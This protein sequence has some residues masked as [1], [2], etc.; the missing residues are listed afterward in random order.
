[1]LVIVGFIVV[2]VSIL[3][4][5]M[6]AGGNPILLLQFAEFIV[7]GGSAIG[8]VLIAAPMK[9]IKKIMSEL[10]KTI[11]QEHYSKE[12]FLVLLKS[13]N[14]LFLVAQRDGLL[15]IERH[16]EKPEESEILSRSKKFIT[17]ETTRSFFCDSMK[18][19]LSGGIPPHELES[20][21]EAEIETFDMESKPV[22]GQISK[23][24]D[25]LPGLGIVAA[26]LGIIVTMSSIDDG[27][28]AVG[29]HV[30]A[31]LVGTFLGV[32]MA[33]GFVNPLA[34]NI[35]HNV[36]ARVRLLETIK[37][38]ITAYAKGNP[39]IVA[40]EIARRTIFSDERPTFAELEGF[41]R[42]KS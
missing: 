4:G 20:L 26:V 37:T 31:A 32:L 42:A 39:P 8:S 5:F 23:M 24:G 12:D 27:A 2:I 17:N 35:E 11:K 22:A 41:I 15:A 38:C 36:E 6:I 28:A 7:I 14:D 40:V 3:G 18:V 34:A 21:M 33:Y 16:I 1:M 30:A 19:M 13:Y 9:L 29:K 25:S 10:P